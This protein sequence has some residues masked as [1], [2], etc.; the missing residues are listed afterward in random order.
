MV[1]LD[2][3]IEK[4]RSEHVNFQPFGPPFQL[5]SQQERWILR[6]GFSCPQ[7]TSMMDY[8]LPQIQNICSRRHYQMVLLL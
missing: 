4:N 3:L 5:G 7:Q 2:D 8:I 1:K 6:L